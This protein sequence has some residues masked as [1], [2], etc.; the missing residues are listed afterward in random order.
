MVNPAPWGTCRRRRCPA[1]VP[2]PIR[3]W[4]HRLLELVFLVQRPACLRE[5][6]RVHGRKI[7]LKACK[8]LHCGPDIPAERSHC[9]TLA[10]LIPVQRGNCLALRCTGPGRLQPRL[11]ASRSL[12]CAGAALIGPNS[13]HGYL[14]QFGW[15]NCLVGLVPLQQAIGLHDCAHAG[16]SAPTPS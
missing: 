15:L 13:W 4:R 6:N 16:R 5:R 12:C 7:A 8:L 2:S 10:A 9:R 3:L 11:Y 1:T 14:E